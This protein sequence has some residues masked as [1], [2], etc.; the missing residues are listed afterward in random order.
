MVK[1]AIFIANFFLKGGLSFYLELDK[2]V[3]W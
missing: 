3:R 1:G 2:K